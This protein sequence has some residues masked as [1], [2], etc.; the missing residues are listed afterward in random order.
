MNYNNTPISVIVPI[1]PPHLKHIPP[2][3][4]NMNEQSLLPDEVILCISEISLE[5]SQAILEKHTTNSKFELVIHGTPEKQNQS[6]NRN[7]G[8]LIAK[9]KFVMNCDADDIIHHEKIEIMKYI[10]GLRPH[11]NLICHN[12]FYNRHNTLDKSVLDF[13]VNL[14]NLFLHADSNKYS[15]DT[16]KNLP[17]TNIKIENYPVH[18]AHVLF[19]K[20]CGVLYREEDGI[21]N[22]GEDGQFCQDILFRHGNIVYI[23]EKLMLYN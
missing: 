1:Y 12:Y 13:S 2:L 19:N 21:R 16:K 20:E 17:C 14:K 5:D 23:E 15:R 10:L 11:T 18:H 4:K 22:N 9:H 3:I 8:I 6:Q 7:R